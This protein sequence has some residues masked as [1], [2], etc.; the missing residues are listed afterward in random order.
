MKRLRLYA[1]K[2]LIR[3]KNNDNKKIIHTTNKVL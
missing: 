2:M 3:N 1:M